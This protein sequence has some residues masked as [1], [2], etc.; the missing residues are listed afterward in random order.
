MRKMEN[1]VF[2]P[3]GNIFYSLDTFVASIGRGS[4]VRRCWVD[5]SSAAEF[6]TMCPTMVPPWYHGPTMLQLLQLLLCSSGLDTQCSRVF[7]IVCA[8]VCTIHSVCTNYIVCHIV[9]HR[10]KTAVAP[11][12]SGSAVDHSG[13]NILLRYIR[14][15]C[16]HLNIVI[17]TCHHLFNPTCM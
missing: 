7:G 6:T 1:Y 3:S 2:S 11:Q 16:H 4:D 15:S 8:T 9:C 12:C 10:Y 13:P 17:L 5:H 14:T